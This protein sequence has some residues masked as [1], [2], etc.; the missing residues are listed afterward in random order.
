MRVSLLKAGGS[1]LYGRENRRGR[2]G[3]LFAYVGVIHRCL[4]V[5]VG[6][7][8]SRDSGRV[9]SDIGPVWG[10]RRLF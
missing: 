10:V 2:E 6:E 5:G 8:V 3:D 4:G 1:L 7:G 9:V